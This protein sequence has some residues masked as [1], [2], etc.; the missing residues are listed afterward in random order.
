MQ[1]QG[2]VG[3]GNA[4]NQN[5]QQSMMGLQTPAL[6]AQLQRHIPNQGNMMGGN[7]SNQQ[8]Q[9]YSHQTQQY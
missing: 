1:N 6:V 5:P 4:N 9:Q 8:Q 3:G 2:M 7:Q